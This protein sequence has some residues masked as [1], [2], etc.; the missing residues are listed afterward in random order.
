VSSL[1]TDVL[2]LT[3]CITQD[4]D[5]TYT[6]TGS[7][8][9][10]A[11]DTA[12]LKFDMEIDFVDIYPYGA[13]KSEGGTAVADQT[14]LTYASDP[15]GQDLT[16]AILQTLTGNTALYDSAN[17]K[18]Q[19]CVYA[20]TLD[21]ATHVG[22]DEVKVSVTYTSG[23]ITGV[24]FD[25]TG[26]VEAPDVL[27]LEDTIDASDITLSQFPGTAALTQGDFLTMQVKLNT[28]LET[29]FRIDSL[30][31]QFGIG[32]EGAGDP[33]QLAI[34]NNVAQALTTYNY[35]PVPEGGTACSAAPS[36][37]QCSV[38]Q[39]SSVPKA[40]FF[41]KNAGIETISVYCTVTVSPLMGR[42][43]AAD[44]AGETIEYNLESDVLIE[45]PEEETNS[46]IPFYAGIGAACVGCVGFV[47][48]AYY[49]YS[50]KTGMS[51]FSSATKELMELNAKGQAKG[52]NAADIEAQNYTTE[53]E[54]FDMS[55]VELEDDD[56][57]S[58]VASD[59]EE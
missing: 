47:A 23:D 17:E 7:G 35:M 9:D 1:L 24:T 55:D 39:F 49:S 50:V 41:M 14:G 25:A 48:G 38:L 51:S 12:T 30:T 58:I 29:E 21:G 4:Y 27:V 8:F 26:E 18:A 57:D 2:L 34:T 31:C 11:T 56:D 32:A 5:I 28:G 54:D 37:E 6:A 46:S 44:G 33:N 19:F 52:A 20:A 3:K 10:T 36:S 42:R 59:T 16:I 43:L 53:E 22:F 15:V 40:D 45:I 13:C